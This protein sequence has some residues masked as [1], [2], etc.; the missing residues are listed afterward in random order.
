MDHGYQRFGQAP[1]GGHIQDG[2]AGAEDHD[3]LDHG[4]EEEEGEG[5]TEHRVDD[6]ESFSPVGERSGVTVSWRK[7][8]AVFN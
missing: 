1:A 8:K 2:P 3:A 7:H 4:G 6:T 5:D